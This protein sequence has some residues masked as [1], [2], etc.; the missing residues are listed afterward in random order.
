MSSSISCFHEKKNCR[1]YRILITYT[2]LTIRKYLYILI[3]LKNRELYLRRRNAIKTNVIK[4]SE[5]INSSDAIMLAQEPYILGI[6]YLD[7]AFHCIS[8]SEHMPLY[9]SSI[10]I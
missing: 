9:N 8:I 4:S 2:A 3:S 6:Q 7:L 10:S 5:K 1:K